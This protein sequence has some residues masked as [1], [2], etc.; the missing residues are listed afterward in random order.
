MPI[1]RID[2]L[3]DQDDEERCVIDAVPENMGVEY[4][5]LVKGVACAELMPDPARLHMAPDREGLGLP[6][7]LPNTQSMLILRRDVKRTLESLYAGAIEYFPFQLIDHRGRV[8]SADYVIVNPLGTVDC[9]DHGRSEID[10]FKDTRR[11]VGIDKLVLDAKKLEGAPCLFRIEEDKGEYFIDDRL[12]KAFAAGDFPGIVLSEV[13]V[14][15][16]R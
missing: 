7:L 11:V 13:D 14:S 12:R 15:D 4:W 6:A 9:I 1:W 8:H 5:R 10:Y 3:G 16:G 2:V